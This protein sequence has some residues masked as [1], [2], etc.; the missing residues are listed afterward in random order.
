MFGLRT[1]T[2]ALQSQMSPTTIETPPLDENNMGDEVGVPKVHEIQAG[3]STKADIIKRAQR[4]SIT[5]QD[6]KTQ[7]EATDGSP[8]SG[9][10]KDQRKRLTE[11]K[12]CVVN[13]KLQ[14]NRARTTKTEIKTEILEAVDRLFKLLKEAEADKYQTLPIIRGE[15]KGEETGDTTYISST[16][17]PSFDETQIIKRLE[18]H[19][20]IINR[21]TEEVKKLQKCIEKDLEEK[22]LLTYASVA[23]GERKTHRVEQAVMHSIAVAS[24]DEEETGEEVLQKIRIAINAKESGVLVDKVRKARDR[25]VIVGCGTR[26]EREKVM[27]RLKNADLQVEEIKNKDP[28]VI[29][30]DVLQINTDDDILKALKNQNKGIFKDIKEEE[31]R[32]EIRYRRRTRNPLLGHVIMRVSPKIWLNMTAAGAVHIDLQRVR[33]A[34]QSPLVQCSMCLGHGHG[35]RLCKETQEKCSHCGGVHLKV[36]CPKWQAGVSPICCNCTQAGMMAVNHNAFDL[37][38]AVRKKWEALARA[39]IAYC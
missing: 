27:Q 39:T 36:N 26:E 32:I 35:R 24:K 9:T 20:E 5:T 6:R 19:A 17:P 11:A 16:A 37:E 25:K 38:C 31:N 28:L 15:R 34:D 21:N 8:T 12:S 4:G 10:K 3:T 23:S 22:R 7:P 33:V 14:L 18:E 2:K 13:I 29:L 1:P 30:K